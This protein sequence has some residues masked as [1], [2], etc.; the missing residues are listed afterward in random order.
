MPLPLLA[1]LA[2]A[3]GQQAISAVGQEIANNREHRQN[4]QYYNMQRQDALKDWQ[5][6]NEYN[7]PSAQVERLRQAGISP[8]ISGGQAA[9]ASQAQQA[10][11]ANMAAA[12][13]AYQVN[14]GANAIN[15]AMQLEQ[16][17]N[18]Q[19]QTAKT[20]E[21]AKGAAVDTKQ[22]ELVYNTDS[23]TM[24]SSKFAALWTAE[25]NEN[26]IKANTQEKQQLIQNAKLAAEKAVQEISLL[27]IEGVHRNE[28]LR[29]KNQLQQ[30]QI[31]SWGLQMAKLRAEIRSINT[32][33]SQDIQMFPAKM[34]QISEQIQQFKLGNE[35]KTYENIYAPEHL[36]ERNVQDTLRNSKDRYELS[37]RET[38]AP[39]LRELLDKAPYLIHLFKSALR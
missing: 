34:R 14:Q 26:Y 20:T 7:A 21:E 32:H 37:K 3:A 23:E 10:R 35:A 6:N 5:R 2:I 9:I 27:K 18:L 12:P 28:S 38:I 17:K 29:G 39:E 33:T 4:L 22:K 8:H 30:Q 24:R 1:P 31:N 36:R 13:K 15:T 19:A 16:M 25:A 11:G